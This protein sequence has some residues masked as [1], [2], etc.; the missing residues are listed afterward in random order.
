MTRYDGWFLAAV[1][2]LT[3]VIMW[4]RS[5]K[6]H[7]RTISPT[8]FLLLAAAGPLL[9]LAYNAIVYKNPLEFAN[10]P[11]SA[12]AI[13]RN[14]TATTHPGSQQ[15]IEAFTFFLRAAELNVAQGNWGRLWVVSLLCGLG[16]LVA[17]GVWSLLLLLIPLPFYALSVAYS[18]VPIY[19]P[20]W[21]PFAIYNIRYGLALLPA[22]AVFTAITIASVASRIRPSN[23]RTATWI[24]SIA[25]L[26]SS[27]GFIWHSSPVCVREAVINSR[28]RLA[29]EKV[30]VDNLKKLPPNATILMALG[31]HAAAVQAAGIPLRRVIHETNHRTWMK[32]DDPDGI[33]ERALH[34]PQAYASYV[35]A[36][37]DDPIDRKVDKQQL[38]SLIV[39][40]ALGEHAVTLYSTIPA[41]K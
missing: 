37:Q 39:I 11:Y 8:R 30:M 22:F 4:L 7:R 18:G 17:R 33:W 24:A 26:A 20:G 3:V 9:W 21:W 16:I 38:N 32:P 15:P 2:S 34:D 10:G 35:V 1:L 36:T 41:E 29:I 14:S 28:G 13:E 31:E 25:L 6:K 19:V 5:V 12:A 40:Q 23:L 27:Y